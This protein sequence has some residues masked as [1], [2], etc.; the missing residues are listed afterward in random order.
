MARMEYL[1]IL[2]F[3]LIVS[4]VIHYKYHIKLYNSVTQMAVCVGFFFVVGITWDIVG[5]TRGHWEFGY[6]NL[7]GIRVSI[8]PFEEVLFML[9]VPYSILVF[10]KLFGMKIS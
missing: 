6:E 1:F 8:L 7:T 4:A 2:L 3:W 9:V 5:A 10:Y